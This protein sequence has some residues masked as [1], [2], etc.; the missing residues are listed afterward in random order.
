MS[1]PEYV[2]PALSLAGPAAL[3]FVILRFFPSAARA[4]VVLLA[5]I[6]AIVTRDPQRREASLTVLDKL[7][8]GTPGEKAEPP[9]Q[10]SQAPR[11]ALLRPRR[12]N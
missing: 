5:G 8:Q 12:R 4:V 3:A 11:R 9:D 2:V 7:S 6:A 1:L 10:V